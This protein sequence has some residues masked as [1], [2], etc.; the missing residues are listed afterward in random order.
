[1]TWCFSPLVVMKGVNANG[2]DRGDCCP[3]HDWTVVRA[4]AKPMSPRPR[5]ATE[6][7]RESTVLT[8]CL[9]HGTR[10]SWGFALR[11]LNS[12][13][14]Y[15]LIGT[16]MYHPMSVFYARDLRK[17]IDEP[18]NGSDVLAQSNE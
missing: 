6:N 8:T 18:S 14:G 2:Q 13:F 17:M 11:S 10:H 1:M 15:Q 12:I 3:I 9:C 5:P 4:L 7:R 16:G